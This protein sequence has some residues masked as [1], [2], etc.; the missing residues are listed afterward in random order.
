MEETS[1]P[2][3]CSLPKWQG[4]EKQRKPGEL[5]QMKGDWQ[6]GQRDAAVI[7][8]LE[9]GWENSAVKDIIAASGEI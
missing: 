2:L 9:P 3:A 5:L 4:Q 8:G 1:V 6:T 7:V